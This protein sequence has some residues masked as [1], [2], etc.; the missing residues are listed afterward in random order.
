MSRAPQEAVPGIEYDFPVVFPFCLI[1]GPFCPMQ[2]F[3]KVS[4]EGRHVKI[5]GYITSKI[6]GPGW[7]L[8]A[9]ACNPDYQEAEIRRIT[10]RSQPRQI[11]AETLS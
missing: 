6:L 7:A 9:H 8:V 10:V 4:R 5:K 3:D 11:V 1:W 2:N